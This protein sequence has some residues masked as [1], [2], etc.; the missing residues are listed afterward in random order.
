MRWQ[1]W[2]C[3]LFCLNACS[4]KAESEWQLY[5]MTQGELTLSVQETG[6]LGSAQETAIYAPFDGTLTQLIPEG[7]VVKKGEPLGRFETTL[8]Q[9]ERDSA[10]LSLQ[11]AQLD[12]QLAIL[13]QDW[14]SQEVRFNGGQ[15]NLQLQL[16]NIK[17]RQL[18][19]ER[20]TVALTS[21][22]EGL[23]SLD[24]R[25]AILELEARERSR[26]F[27]LGYL[28]KE[29]R[30]QARLQ[31]DEASKEKE[32]LQAELQVLQQGARPQELEKQTL[33][34]QKARGYQSQLKQEAQVQTRVAQV[35]KRS[36]DGRM[37][38]YQ[39]RL[40]YYRGLIE[41]GSLRAPVAGT[42]IYGKLQVGQEEIPIK[43]G[44]AIKEGVTVLRLVD[45]EQ[46]LVRT[47]IHEIDAPRVQVGQTVRISLDAWPELALTGV[48]QRILP[49]ASQ[50][51]SNDALELRSFASEI[52]LD[53]GDPRLRPG[54][55][56]NVEILTGKFEQ[57]L[58]VPSQALVVHGDETLCWVLT[59]DAEPQRRVLKTGPSDA[60][61]TLILSGLA[62]G[63]QVILN[64]LGLDPGPLLSPA[65]ASSSPEVPVEAASDEPA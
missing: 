43:A 16:E 21:T 50:S 25:M 56:A 31:L 4:P 65:P 32:R 15:A 37:A 11:E 17:L 29:E 20:D 26:L 41:K 22:R 9:Q 48:L 59:G 3:F 47:T 36:A 52:L 30:D 39:D 57:V 12:Q 64:P 6:E 42:V 61:Q 45:L 19:E 35:M 51:L 44:D 14:R 58:T 27:D 34:V 7:S 28:S 2:L 60:R 49:V 23:K 38:R 46:P 5:T 8:Q 1:V 53:A 40:N 33:Q 13:E 62:V 18:K 54:M 24:Q 10:Q 55:T 63:E